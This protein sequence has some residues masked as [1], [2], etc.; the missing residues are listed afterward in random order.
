MSIAVCGRLKFILFWM[1]PWVNAD[2]LS[3]FHTQRDWVNSLC[4]VNKNS[5]L[6]YVHTQMG[7]C[8]SVIERIR[9][10][11]ARCW[12]GFFL[13]KHETI[14]INFLCEMYKSSWTHSFGC[15]LKCC[16]KQVQ[17]TKSVCTHKNKTETIEI[18]LML[19]SMCE[20]RSQGCIVEIN[21][22]TAYSCSMQAAGQWQQYQNVRVCI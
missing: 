9:R 5:S 4:T 14:L 3:H 6:F 2:F 7:F 21:G 10:H 12:I 15:P 20:S 1:W 18:S 11:L 22:E 16:V 19:I 13:C 8:F 17:S